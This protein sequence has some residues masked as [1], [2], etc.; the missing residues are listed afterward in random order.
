MSFNQIEEFFDLEKVEG[1]ENDRPRTRE[2]C[3]NQPRPCLWIGCRYHLMFEWLD[4][5]RAKMISPFT[6]INQLKETCALDVADRGGITCE[7]IA[8]MLNTSRERIRQIEKKALKKL[9]ENGVL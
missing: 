4:G 8:R 6:E 3:R 5:P 9:K 7:E 2:D 1:G